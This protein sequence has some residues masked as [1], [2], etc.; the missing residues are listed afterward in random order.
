METTIYD[1]I[2]NSFINAF[3]ASK[4]FLEFGAFESAARAIGMIGATLYIFSRIWGPLAMGEPINFFPLMRPFILL[5]AII[6]SASIC[7]SMDLI[8]KDVT[9]LTSIDQQ[10]SIAR[11]KIDVA[12]IER[13]KRYI[14]LKQIDEENQTKKYL[15]AFQNP[16][17]SVSTT[18]VFHPGA[19]LMGVFISNMTEDFADSL[20]EG[21]VK[22]MVLVFDG[23]GIVGYFVVTLF[24]MFLISILKFVAPLAFAFAIFDGFTNNASEWFAKYINALLM[25]LLCKAYTIFTYYLQLPFIKNSLEWETGQTALYLVV[26]VLC[27]VGYFFVPTMANMALSVGGV[28][29]TASVAG[30]RTIAMK[31]VASNTAAAGGRAAMGAGGAA[32]AAGRSLAAR[33]AKK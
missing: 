15:D 4:V 27:V 31:N 19:T 32:I 24:A 23:L 13:E 28:G 7:N 30:Q 10:M 8:Y 1:S 21:L 25:L 22:T 17:G 16:D 26:I 20:Q 12:I 9:H 2:N 29:P 5:V 11:K 14:L 6:G 18:A 33:F 3:E